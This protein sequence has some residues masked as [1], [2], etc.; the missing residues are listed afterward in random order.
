MYFANSNPFLSSYLSR[1]SLCSL[2]WT[3][4]QRIRKD[5]WEKR[6]WKG[7]CDH[8]KVI[9]PNKTTKEETDI[10]N[11]MFIKICHHFAVMEKS[12]TAIPNDFL[13][14]HDTYPIK[15]D[16]LSSMYGTDSCACEALILLMCG[17]CISHCKQY[18][19]EWNVIG[20][21]GQYST[22]QSPMD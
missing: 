11:L 7:V 18:F 17:I 16:L 8:H 13:K 15:A 9:K 20:K 2:L 5:E 6:K 12:R 4:G 3:S 19:F 22:E 14:N 1:F 21:S 10:Y